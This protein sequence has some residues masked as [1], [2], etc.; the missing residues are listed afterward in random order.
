MKLKLE[1][2]LN[3]KQQIQAL[4]KA[5]DERDD[6]AKELEKCT[7]HSGEIRVFC[8]WKLEKSVFLIDN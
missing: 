2:E 4:Q 1:A 6:K 7:R 8:I 5:H 3:L